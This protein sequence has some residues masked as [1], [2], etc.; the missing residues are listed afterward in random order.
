MSMVQGVQG[1]LYWGF[2]GGMV[3]AGTGMGQVVSEHATLGQYQQDGWKW[4]RHGL[5]D[6]EAGN[7]P[8]GPPWGDGC[9]QESEA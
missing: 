6:P 9:E 8:L 3:R 2:P 5:W 1:V 7:V 4:G